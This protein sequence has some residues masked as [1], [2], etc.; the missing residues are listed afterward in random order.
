MRGHISVTYVS[1]GRVSSDALTTT[2]HIRLRHHSAASTDFLTK[3]QSAKNEVIALLTVFRR[4][5]Q[6]LQIKTN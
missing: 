3:Q 2:T 6:L 4:Q 1:I 5:L